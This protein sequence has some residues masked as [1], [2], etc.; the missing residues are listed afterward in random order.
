MM[1]LIQKAHQLRLKMVYMCAQN[2]GHIASALSC[3]DIIVALYYGGVLKFD[4]QNPAW[5]D[6]DRFILSKGH[7]EI[8]LY[9]IL[10]DCGFF[11]E[12]WLET[13]YRKGD[14]FLGGHPDK[15][16][17]GVEATTGSL[18]HG[19]SI[20][21]G[22][23]LASK[24]DARSHLQFVLL[25]DAECAEGSIWEAAIFASKHTLD[26]LIAI[27][28]R[29]HLGAMDF[30]ENFTALEPFADK[31]KAYGWEVSAVNGHD[32][33]QLH[34]VFHYGRT[35][36]DNR[37]LVIIAQTTKGKGVSFIENDPTWHTRTLSSD[38]E[39]QRALKELGRTHDGGF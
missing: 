36:C 20:A 15:H 23:S 39:I 26:N 21:A 31:W 38:E 33:Q 24:M 2:G 11:P 3:I 13:R 25:G 5:D 22:I 8:A 4:P 37:P 35:R 27:V 29:N 12:E 14:C 28:D 19:L 10:A 30:T 1:E 16:I 6:R 7:G 18:G 32:L 34:E 17:P 9:A